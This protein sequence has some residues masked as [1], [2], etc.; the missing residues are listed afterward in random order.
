MIDLSVGAV[1]LTDFG[2]GA[3]LTPQR[4]WR[5]SVVGTT[6]WMAPEVIMALEYNEK[7]DI[8]SLGA[9]V[10]EMADRKPPYMDETPMKALF[11]IC[12]DGLPPLVGANVS[13]ELVD[14]I[15]RC[16]AMA[17][18]SRYSAAEL[19][20]H[21]FITQNALDSTKPLV[22]AV[23]ATREAKAKEYEEYAEL[24]E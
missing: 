19:L 18:E 14:F 11:L 12:K 16:T 13:E 17:P 5:T 8:W 21:P 20:E 24:N 7:A 15:A 10:Q 22:A 23:V 1:K 6:F 4:E 9:L 3:R 2:F